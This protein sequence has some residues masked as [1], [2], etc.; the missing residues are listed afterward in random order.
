MRYQFLQWQYIV[1]NFILMKKTLFLHTI[2]RQPKDAFLT[3]NTTLID[4]CTVK[5]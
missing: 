2:S 1:K 5:F 4:E 3:D